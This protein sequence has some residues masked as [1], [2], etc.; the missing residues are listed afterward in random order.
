MNTPMRRTTHE[1]EMECYQAMIDIANHQLDK[2]GLASLFRRL[3][4]QP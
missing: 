3:F 4:S 2:A 1:D